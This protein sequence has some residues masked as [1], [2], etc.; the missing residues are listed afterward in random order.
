MIAKEE[1]IEVSEEEVN[2]ELATMAESFKRSPEEIR[3]ILAANGS[4]SS[5]S[6]EI[7]LRKTIDLLIAS[8]VEVEAVEAPAE[9]ASAE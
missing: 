3:S 2:Q 8:S 5:L 4:L 9:E 7:S 1:N 6:D